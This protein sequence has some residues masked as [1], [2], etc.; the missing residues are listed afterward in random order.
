MWCSCFDRRRFVDFVANKV[1]VPINEVTMTRDFSQA[2]VGEDIALYWFRNPS[3]L[4]ELPNL[5]VVAE[6]TISDFFA[7]ISTYFRHLR[8]FS[9]HCRVITPSMMSFIQDVPDGPTQ[10]PHNLADIGLVIAEAAV[11]SKFSQLPLSAYF[12]TLSYVYAEAFRRYPGLTI[13][14][15]LAL[16]KIK[17]LW[18]SG[19]DICGQ[20]ALALS[21]E[22][23]NDVWSLV[24]SARTAAQTSDSTDPII[25]HALLEIMANGR[26]GDA[27][28]TE[29]LKSERGRDINIALEGSR[30]GR[31]RACDVLIRELA[32][33]PDSTRRRRAFLSG[34]AVSRIQPGTLDH[35]QV[36]V[37]AGYPL[38][39]SALWYGACAGLMPESSV[40][41]FGN[42]IALLLNRELEREVRLLDPPSCDIGLLELTTIVNNRVG[43]KL[44]I[45]TMVPGLLKIE[46][47]PLVNMVIRAGD[48]ETDRQ[49][50]T[51]HQQS[52]FNDDI[53]LHY[54][55]EILMRLDDVSASVRA[56]QKEVEGQLGLKR[57]RQPYK[58]RK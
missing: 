16:D 11:Y 3:R 1:P 19:K 51:G 32:D 2:P 57:P 27:C 39:E 28:L 58:S 9:A 25:S 42:G 53:R 8:P 10:S 21:A 35:F 40:D 7:W 55:R 56:I 41:V 18:T 15:I 52:L 50:D 34:Y 22:T 33:G 31:V 5:I 48:Q 20:P 47:I 26:I 37:K 4:F 30:E 43:S 12:R 13:K 23:I 46:I 14:D 6:E 54:G 24:V 44:Q 36:L 38:N 29:L 17:N 49:N 45:P